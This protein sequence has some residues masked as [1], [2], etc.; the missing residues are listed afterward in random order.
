MLYGVWSSGGTLGNVSVG[1]DLTVR[2]SASGY[3]G[4]GNYGGVAASA[5]DCSYVVVYAAIGYEAA[6][7]E[8]EEGSIAY[9][10]SGSKN[11]T[12]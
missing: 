8:N 1:D 10:G 6:V 7:E 2:N 11:G 12:V 5:R 9:S 3:G 4:Y